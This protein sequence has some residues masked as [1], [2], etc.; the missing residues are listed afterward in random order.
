MIVT[1]LNTKTKEKVTYQDNYMTYTKNE[2]P[3]F[4]WTEGN[5][6][7]DC[8]RELF[9]YR[10]KHLKEPKDPKCGNSR[11]RVKLLQGHLKYDEIER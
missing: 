10:A 4:I 1:I 6:S 11:Y 2:W 9:F 3:P 7:C 5:Y 8:N